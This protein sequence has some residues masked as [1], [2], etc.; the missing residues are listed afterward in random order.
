MH[1]KSLSLVYQNYSAFLNFK[2]I[3]KQLYYSKINM[4]CIPQR[5]AITLPFQEMK[6]NGLEPV[7]KANCKRIPG[8]PK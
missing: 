1:G 7:L 8:I 4:K 2:V 5:Q 6:P 3:K